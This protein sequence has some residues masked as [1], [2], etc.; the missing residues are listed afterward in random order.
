MLYVTPKATREIKDHNNKVFLD[1]KALS[2]IHTACIYLLVFAGFFHLH[3]HY[4]ACHS[5]PVYII[6]FLL[7]KLCM[8]VQ[9]NNRITE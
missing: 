9:Q 1:Q 7:H 6:P 2:C 4:L 3:L 5:T 8:W